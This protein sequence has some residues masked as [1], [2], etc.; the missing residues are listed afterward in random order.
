MFL[1]LSL[2]T[3]G[4]F[5]N[6]LEMYFLQYSEAQNNRI[7][8]NILINHN[9]NPHSFCYYIQANAIF[10]L[11]KEQLCS[12]PNTFPNVRLTH[13]KTWLKQRNFLILVFIFHN[14]VFIPQVVFMENQAR[15]LFDINSFGW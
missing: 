13:R 1:K 4:S 2:K 11:I 3:Q 5:F 6:K 14:D 8:T 12:L 10:F 15:N 9:L 7:L